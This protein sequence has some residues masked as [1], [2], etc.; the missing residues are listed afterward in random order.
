MSNELTSNEVD[1]LMDLDPVNL[2]AQDLD[3][4]ILT[5]RKWR[6]DYQAGVKP[7]KA[8]GQKQTLDIGSL[9]QNIT[10]NIEG[11][12]ITPPSSGGMRR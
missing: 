3:K 7:K 9:V 4:I 11:P 12:T 1:L 10:K 8:T 6:A 5:H 2:S